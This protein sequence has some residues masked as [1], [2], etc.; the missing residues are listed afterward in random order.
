MHYKT[1]NHSFSFTLTLFTLGNIYSFLKLGLETLFH[2]KAF[3]NEIQC[4]LTTIFQMSLGKTYANHTLVKD[5][6]R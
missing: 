1:A 6:D 2:N 5:T 3:S 4:G